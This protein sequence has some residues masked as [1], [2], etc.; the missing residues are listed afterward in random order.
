VPEHSTA[1]YDILTG[2]PHFFRESNGEIQ[3]L[4]LPESIT[5]YH[6]RYCNSPEYS[7]I[8]KYVQINPCIM[9]I[10]FIL[11]LLILLS[12]FGYAQNSNEEAGNVNVDSIINDLRM[13]IPEY[14]Q[15][16]NVPGASIALV[17]ENKVIWAEG[18]GVANSI[19]KKPVNTNTLFEVASISK[20]V[21]AYIALRLVDEGKLS[22]DRPLFS[23]LSRE[24]MPYSVYQDSIKLRHALSH[25]SGLNKTKR[26]IMFKPGSSYYYS[27]NGF[28]LV[29]DVMEEVTG[30]TLEDLA[31]RL[32]FKPLGMNNSSF[33]KKDNLVSVTSNG[34]IHAIVPIVIFGMMFLIQY[35]LVTLVGA[36]I[37]RLTTKS[38]KLRFKHKIIFIILSVL[39]STG[40]LFLFLGEASLTEFA[41][42]TFFAGLTSLSLF[43]L[44]VHAVKTLLSGTGLN[45]I[46][47]R[48]ISIT[49]GLLLSGIFFLI[50]LKIINLPVPKWPD[51]KPGAAGTLRT[52]PSD[53]ALFMIEIADPRFLKAETSELLRTP[54]IKLDEDLSWG[55]GPGIFYSEEW[56]I[57]WQWG[58]HIDFQSIMMICPEKQYGVI[59]CTNNDLLNPDVAFEIAQRAFRGNFESIRSAI[60]LGYDYREQ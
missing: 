17:N 30:E 45:K 55:M 56:Y 60:H 15:I 38:W 34:H 28:N 58:Q 29:K 6:R 44:L 40:I 37:I 16:Q 11:V 7:V 3:E 8:R 4:H 46:Y 50:S 49:W 19:T 2:I 14:L 23:Y 57:L 36:V 33:V 27:A 12:S 42:T 24:W 26:E 13:F 1:L 39:I 43:L 18:F 47:Q 51:Y 41:F 53:L 52:S 59:V 20:V 54:Q 48:I 22:L 9:K 25:S 35:L 10:K 32:V 21:T 31:Q 5:L